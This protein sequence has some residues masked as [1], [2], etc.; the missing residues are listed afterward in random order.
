MNRYIIAATFYCLSSIPISVVYSD[1]QQDRSDNASLA[2]EVA[3]G[4]LRIEYEKLLRVIEKNRNPVQSFNSVLDIAGRPGIGAKDS[5]V[6]LVEFSDYQ[7]AFCRRH[8]M[9]AAQEIREKLV[10][11]KQLRYV[12]LDFPMETRHPLAARAATAARC[13]EEQGKYWEMRSTMYENQKALDEVFLVE[14]AKNVGL[15]EEAFSNCQQSGQ[16]DTAIQQD[17]LVGRSLGIKGTPTFFLGINNGKEIKLI[18]K[19]Q[20]A[21]PYKVFE[22]EILFAVK[23]ANNN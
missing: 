11:G 9:G 1:T 10:L 13:A 18:R 6:I 19:I 8:Q 2:Q 3:A 5:D 12:F 22:R 7:C 15:N 17:Q 16:Y 21:Q 4:N 23:L 20:G 14:H